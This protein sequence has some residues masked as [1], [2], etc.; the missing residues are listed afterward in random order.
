MSDDKIYGLLAQF[1]DPKHLVHAAE[2]LNKVG[3]SRVE[4]YT[5]F[6]VEGIAAALRFRPFSVAVI[7]LV[8]ALLS[9]GA[10]YFMQYYASVIAYPE[11]VGGRP[12][13]SW[14][15]FIPITFELGVLGGVLGGVFGMLLLNRLPRYS[16][17]V[18]NVKSFLGASSDAFF[19]CV[20]ASDPHFQRELTAGLL[21]RIGATE[22]TEV[23][24]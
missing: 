7:F 12:P 19:L 15:S 20:E 24:L 16:H 14:P 22:V 10:G 13:Q 3:Y 17:P 1:P 9:A 5:P 18:S 6:A 23:P 11:N 4:S 8:A 21:R 2:E